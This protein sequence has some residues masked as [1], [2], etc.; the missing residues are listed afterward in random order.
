M[1]E[2]FDVVIVGSGAGGGMAAH[3][4]T[5]AGARVAIVE[6]GGHNMDRDLRHHQWPWELPRRDGY[7]PDPVQVRLTTKEEVV[8]K[9][10]EDRV[11]IFDGNAHN[12]FY[13]NHFFVKI[14]DWKYTHP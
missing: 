9:G 2:I 3:V 12:S 13:Q 14:R 7:F 8:G 5:S 6:A 4:L 11:T 10:I 1:A